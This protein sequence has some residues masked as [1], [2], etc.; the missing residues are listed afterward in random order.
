MTETTESAAQFLAAWHANA[1][2][3]RHTYAPSQ[4]HDACGVG[5]IARA[6]RQAAAATW[7]R[8]ASTR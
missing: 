5:F 6:G 4:E 3:L 7:W 1:A 2:A 8:P